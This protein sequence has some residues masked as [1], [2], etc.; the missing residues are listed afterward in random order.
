MADIVVGVD[1]S[2]PSA[3]ALR[4]AARE[5]G[6]RGARLVAVLVW[7]LFNQR[8]AD[9]TRR[10][11]PDY[12]QAAADAALAAFVEETLGAGPDAAGAVERRPVCDRPAAGL[13]AAAEGADLLVVGAR[14]LGG[15][16]GL[17]LGSVSQECLHHAS[18]PIAVVRGAGAEGREPTGRVVVGVDGS[19]PSASALRWALAYAAARAGTVEAV[20]AW[21]LPLIYGPAVAYDIEAVERAA[22]R[23]VDAAVA[24]ATAGRPD[25][26]GVAVT[27]TVLAGGPASSLL[28]SAKDADAIVVGRRGLGGFGRLLLGSVSEHVVRH[29]ETTVVV[30]P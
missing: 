2:A 26:A 27:P 7:D 19:G 6:V 28:E 10:F 5:A 11:D 24:D 15:L 13:L 18:G 9:G 29:A 3:V 4:W 16:R 23:L 21:E 30:V 1:G 25:L 22:H 14:G 8:H 20:H 17:L 12:D